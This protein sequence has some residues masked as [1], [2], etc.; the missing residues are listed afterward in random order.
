LTAALFSRVWPDPFSRF[1]SAGG[2]GGVF[3]AIGERAEP[4]RQEANFPIPP[5]GVDD[6]LERLDA[7]ATLSTAVQ[8]V[9]ELRP[10]S[11]LPDHKRIRK[12]TVSNHTGAHS[13]ARQ[14]MPVKVAERVADRVL[15]HLLLPAR[16]A[17]ARADLPG[18]PGQPGNPR[19]FAKP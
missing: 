13:D 11:L 2:A 19:K 7:K 15:Q 8:Q 3:P 1:R 14:A 6:G 4:A 5:G 9:V 16:G 18:Q 10:Q 17:G 12:K